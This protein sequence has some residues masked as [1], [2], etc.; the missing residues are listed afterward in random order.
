[1]KQNPFA[2]MSVVAVGLLAFAV[3]ADAG[4]KVKVF[5]LAGQSN[6]EGKAR[7]KLA[8]Y[9][10]NDPGTADHFKHLRHEGEWKVREDAWIKFLERHG[11]L[12]MGYGS[13]DCTGVELEFGNALADHFDEPVLLIKAAWGGHSLY[14]P[15]RPPSAGLPSEEKLGEQLEQARRRVIADNEKN[16][17]DAPLPTMEE[18]KERYGSSYRNLMKE[19]EETLANR[20]TLFPALA[21]REPEIAGFVWFQGWNDQYG[22]AELE[23]ASNM[24][25]F[26]DDVRKDL[27]A[28]KLP[29][30]IGL[31]GQNGSEPAKGAMLT[32]QEAQLAM[33]VVP[34]FAGNVKAVRTDVL[35]DEAA[36]A[37][38]PT[39]RENT[40]QWDKVGSDFAYHYYGSPIWFNRMGKA[41]GE[42]MLE[43]IEKK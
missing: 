26:I 13:R 24:Q 34:E 39:W 11:G 29:F 19:V 42:A 21:G 37:L 40:E 32:I 16:Q 36:E 7:D 28:P 35:V 14:E 6:M 10:A 23:Y 38:F 5:I 43:L 30:V 15:F 22:G 25:H 31:M 18:I 1:M 17:R 3:A 4:D 33:E 2:P 20:D 27:D 9:Q 41:F 12:G 8:E